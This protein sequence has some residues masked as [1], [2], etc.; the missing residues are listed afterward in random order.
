[1]RCGLIDIRVTKGGRFSFPVPGLGFLSSFYSP[2]SLN[3]WS[4]SK[5]FLFYTAQTNVRIIRLV[6]RLPGLQVARRS[7][8][9]HAIEKLNLR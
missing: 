4:K 6:S 9:N 2:N 8:C 5:P 1:M 3:N 7:S